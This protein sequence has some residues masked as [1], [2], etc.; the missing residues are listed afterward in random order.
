MQPVTGNGRKTPARCHGV[1]VNRLKGHNL[2]R[3]D[4]AAG[5]V[6][7]GGLEISMERFGIKINRGA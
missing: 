5:E 6:E 3:H 1:V 7:T 4:F 2:G